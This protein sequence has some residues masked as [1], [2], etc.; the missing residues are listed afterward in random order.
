MPDKKTTYSHE[1]IQERL[2]Q[3]PGWRYEGESIQRVYETEGWQDALM[4]V[5]AIGF[6]AEAGVH[7]PDLTVSWGCD[8]RAVNTQ[9]Q[10]H[11]RQRFRSCP[12]VRRGG[13]LAAGDGRRA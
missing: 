12:Q 2:Q 6:C 5:N 3:L 13:A 7:Q 11:N 4:L 9:R 8:R 10:R 1:Q